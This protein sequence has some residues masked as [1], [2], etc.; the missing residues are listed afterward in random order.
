MKKTTTREK[1]QTKKFTLEFPMNDMNNSYVIINKNICCCIFFLC[2]CQDNKPK[3]MRLEPRK[4]LSFGSSQLTVDGTVKH[5]SILLLKTWN[6]I[7]ISLRVD[8]KNVV[9]VVLVHITTH[10]RYSISSLLRQTRSNYF[11]LSWEFW[12]ECSA[13]FSVN[14]L[15]VR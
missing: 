7:L 13:F 11:F 5:L 8:K 10:F 4:Y 14:Q 1:A 15:K 12:L 9:H 2:V 6:I 3:K